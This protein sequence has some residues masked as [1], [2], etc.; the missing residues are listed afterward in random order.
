MARFGTEKEAADYLGL[1]IATFRDLVGA[2]RLP[3]LVAEFGKY[4]LKAIDEAAD[5][6]SG[7]GKPS[8]RFDQWI[9]ERRRRNARSA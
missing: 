6:I 5:T 2:K 8:N 9:E 3:G 7:V 4:D 1:P